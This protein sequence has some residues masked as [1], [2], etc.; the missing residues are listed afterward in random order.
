MTKGYAAE[1]LNV[2]TS[3][4]AEQEKNEVLHERERESDFGG[5]PEIL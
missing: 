5:D 1:S 3:S 2:K 4:N